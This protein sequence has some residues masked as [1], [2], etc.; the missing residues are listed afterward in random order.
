MRALFGIVSLVVVLA[1][2]GLL[3]KGQLTAQSNALPAAN[4]ASAPQQQS[5]QVQAQFKQSLEGALQQARP[6]PDESK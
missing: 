4:Q 3:A 6:M 5:Q 1:I 2:V